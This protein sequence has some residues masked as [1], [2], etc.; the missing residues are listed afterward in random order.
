MTAWCRFCR[1]KRERETTKNS[2]GPR[3]LKLLLFR[4]LDESWQV[5]REEKKKRNHGTSKSNPIAR[6]DWMRPGG[7]DA[8]RITNPDREPRMRVT[9]A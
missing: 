7:G 1:V 9:N 3:A 4:D 2:R 6:F 8:D 5:N